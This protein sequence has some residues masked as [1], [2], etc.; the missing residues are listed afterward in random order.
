MTA[1]RGMDMATLK[2]FLVGRKGLNPSLN[3]SSL[4]VEFTDGYF[5]RAAAPFIRDYLGTLGDSMLEHGAALP[6]STDPAKQDAIRGWENSPVLGNS[7]IL[8][9][10][11]AMAKAAH[12]ATVEG[13]AAHVDRVREAAV[14]MQ[15][16]ALT[17]WQELRAYSSAHSLLAWP[18]AASI[19]E[20]F[21]KFAATVQRIG[22]SSISQGLLTKGRCGWHCSIAQFRAQVLPNATALHVV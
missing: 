22:V 7:T 13:V 5:G 17:R 19:T 9:V 21:D 8:S 18:F 16:I 14:T 1:D 6:P 4:V 3:T 20:E 12:A 15:F 2:L 10:A 11:G